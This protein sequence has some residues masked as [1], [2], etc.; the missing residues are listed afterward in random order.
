VKKEIKKAAPVLA[1]LFTAG[2]VLM[3]AIGLAIASGI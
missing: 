2:G 3:I 1:S